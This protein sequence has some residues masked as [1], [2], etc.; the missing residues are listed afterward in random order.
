MI[1][2]VPKGKGKRKKRGK[3][4][5][6][7]QSW[8]STICS[9]NASKVIRDVYETDDLRR[10]TPVK[11]GCREDA[12][13]HDPLASNRIQSLSTQLRSLR[14]LQTKKTVSRGRKRGFYSSDSTP[15]QQRRSVPNLTRIRSNSD[16]EDSDFDTS[17][18]SMDLKGGDI[19]NDMYDGSSDFEEAVRKRRSG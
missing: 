17:Y 18:D 5:D 12:V 7:I 4:D 9:A 16:Q 2:P 8:L 6:D 10:N 1:V 15:S 13:Y 19:P 14:T 3:T 11:G